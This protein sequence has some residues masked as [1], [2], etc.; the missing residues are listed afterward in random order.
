MVFVD[1]LE[2]GLVNRFLDS[3]LDPAGEGVNVSLMVH[4]PGWL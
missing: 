1:R 3:Y 2:V 4:R